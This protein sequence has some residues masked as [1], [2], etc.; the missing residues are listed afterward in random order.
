[1]SA[2]HEGGHRQA[3]GCA[4]DWDIRV[5]RKTNKSSHKTNAYTLWECPPTTPSF[6]NF[7]TNYVWKKLLVWR[8]VERKTITLTANELSQQRVHVSDKDIITL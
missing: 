2:G 7:G 5:A 1:M 4:Q 3:H 6:G 8:Y